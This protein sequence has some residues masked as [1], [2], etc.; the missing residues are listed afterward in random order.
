MQ[1]LYVVEA[2]AMSCHIITAPANVLKKLPALSLFV[3]SALF[4]ETDGI[5]LV[6]FNVNK[7]G[8]T[9]HN[10]GGYSFPWFWRFSLAYRRRQ[11]SNSQTE[12]DRQ[13]YPLEVW[14]A[15]VLLI[16]F[17]VVLGIL[18]FFYGDY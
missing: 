12:E 10:S 8:G 16:C 13:R 4:G 11:K 9:T 18:H 14:Q 17:L 15:F 1:A 7:D 5:I 3:S 6:T 2:D